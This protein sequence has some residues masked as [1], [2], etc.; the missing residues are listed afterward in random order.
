MSLLPGQILPPSAPFGRINEDGTVT[1]ETNWWL[2]IYNLCNQS[3]GGQGGLPASALESVETTDFDIS[4]TD[5]PALTRQIAN[6]SAQLP[7]SEVVPALLSVINSLVL[8]LNAA[9]AEV[10]IGSLP[11]TNGGTGQTQYTIGDLLYSGIANALARLAGNITTT[12]KFLTQTGSGSASAAPAWSTISASDLPGTFAGFA[13]PTASVG[14]SAVNGSAA[15]AMRSDAAPPIDQTITPT[16][17]SLHIFN[18]NISVNGSTITGVAN[19]SGTVGLTAVNGTATTL[20]RSDAAPA[21]SQAISPTWSGTHIFSNAITVNGGGSSLKG[22]VTIAAPASGVAL[23]ANGVGS[24]Y[25]GIFT[26]GGTAGTQKG[27]SAVTTTQ[28]AADKIFN[29][30]NSLSNLCDIFGD[31]HGDLGPNLSWTV[32]G[33]W[34]IGAPTSGDAATIANV[35]GAN[36][37]AINGNSAGTAVVRVNTQATTGA[38][39]ASFAATNKPGAANGSPQKWWPINADGTTYYIPLFS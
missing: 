4:T 34:S 21:L 39:T 13:N 5:V 16:W 23:T 12:K 20:M 14:L 18:A 37:L 19:P 29:V 8:A 26:A 9:D 31:G 32:A 36:A 15:T 33:N 35:A 38:Q 3:L 27:L 24:S 25:A 1:I 7:E 10:P 28:N 22:G 6:L 2:L 17:T 30:N 11:A